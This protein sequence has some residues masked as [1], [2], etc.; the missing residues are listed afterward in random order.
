MT[1][2]TTVRATAREL[3]IV[4]AGVLLA[5]FITSRLGATVPAVPPEGVS[6][7]LVTASLGTLA[8]AGL[9]AVGGC[10]LA[11]AITAFLVVA[12]VC[13]AAAR[14]AA[15]RLAPMRT[16]LSV[17]KG[18]VPVADVL[19]DQP[20]T[21]VVHASAL[22]I[23][24]DRHIVIDGAPDASYAYL[25]MS[26]PQHFDGGAHLVVEGV[27]ATGG[28]T[29][30]IQKADAWIA[31]TTIVQAGPFRSWVVVPRDGEYQ[32]VVA[33]GVSAHVPTHVELSPLTLWQ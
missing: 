31:Y 33:Y 16:L 18:L 11:W 1:R 2:A 10:W 12:L 7:L 30:G 19:A 9:R 27:V 25:V 5:A 24:A 22:T 3:A 20:P 28:V 32:L 4:F 13:S 29:V 15:K 23:R 21:W 6:S 8:F 26:E 17:P 14:V